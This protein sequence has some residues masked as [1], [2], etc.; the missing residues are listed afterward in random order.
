MDGDEHP[1]SRPHTIPILRSRDLLLTISNHTDI[2]QH[3]RFADLF[4][5]TWR[6]IPL[7]HRRLLHHHWRTDPF[8]SVGASPR[9]ALEPPMSAGWG[10]RFT[11]PRPLRHVIGICTRHGHELLFHPAVVEKMPD[12]HVKELIAH[13]LGHVY[14]HAIGDT[15]RGAACEIRVDSRA[16]A[17]HITQ[18]VG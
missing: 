17:L 11:R 18:F 5:G 10:H 6:A 14:V 9:I 12:P 1:P 16:N 4:R 13:E 7:H 3:R 8:R 15:S 2:D